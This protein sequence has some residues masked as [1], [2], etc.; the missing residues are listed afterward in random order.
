MIS[1]NPYMKSRTA[2]H[3]GRGGPAL[4]TGLLRCK[5]CG[6]ILHVSYDSRHGSTAYRCMAESSRT[7]QNSCPSIS[8]RP[9]DAEV[10]NEI[11]RVIGGNAVQAA[12]QAIEQVREQQQQYRQALELELEQ[13]RNEAQLAARR[14]EAVD[15]ANRLVAS[16][17]EHRWN[18]SMERVSALERRLQCE[19]RDTKPDLIPDK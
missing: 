18:T 2:P 1:S 14:Y 16:E 12:V 3:T 7:G 10:G 13:A 9:V 5:H 6:W 8:G 4:L 17:L 19:V 11:L 15:P